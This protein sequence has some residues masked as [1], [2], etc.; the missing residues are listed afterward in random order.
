MFWS[1]VFALNLD[2]RLGATYWTHDSGRAFLLY[3]QTL[4]DSFTFK[5]T[6]L[7]KFSELKTGPKTVFLNLPPELT[8]FG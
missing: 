7:F 1:R 2:E 3:D 6:A 8:C 5:F 4:I